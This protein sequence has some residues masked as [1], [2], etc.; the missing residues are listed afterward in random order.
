MSRDQRW[1]RERIEATATGLLRKGLFTIKAPD[2]IPWQKRECMSASF[3]TEFLVRV[4]QTFRCRN[5]RRLGESITLGGHVREILEG[6]MP[7][8]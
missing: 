5:V 8:K 3:V 6:D 7:R 4:H 1:A 2:A